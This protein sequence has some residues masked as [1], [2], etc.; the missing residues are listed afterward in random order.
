M[1][2]GVYGMNFEVMPELQWRWGYPVVMTA[3][4]ALCGILYYRFKRSGWL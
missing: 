4:V 2:A 1:I 3:T